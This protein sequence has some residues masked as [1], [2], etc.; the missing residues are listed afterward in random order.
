[1]ELSDSRGRIFYFYKFFPINRLKVQRNKYRSWA[2]DFIKAFRTRKKDLRA[3]KEHRGKG[4]KGNFPSSNHHPGP[5]VIYS[6]DSRLGKAGGP[7]PS[8]AFESNREASTFRPGQEN[9]G[10]NGGRENSLDP[11]GIFVNQKLLESFPRRK[12]AELKEF[13]GSSPKS[14]FSDGWEEHFDELFALTRRLLR[15]TAKPLSRG[16]IRDDLYLGKALS[17]V[18]KRLPLSIRLIM[19]KKRYIEFCLAYRERLMG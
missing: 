18:H 12:N 9:E 1:M 13:Y 17:E 6:L 8:R 14:A 4:R 2:M 3:R 10:D 16:L 5:L 7:N 15:N 11:R 19:R